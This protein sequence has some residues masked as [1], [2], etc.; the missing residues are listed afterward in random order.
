MLNQNT[1]F[2]FDINIRI[3]DEKALTLLA[4]PPQIVNIES[5]LVVILAAL[6]C[7]L[8]CEVGLVCSG[9][10]C[11]ASSSY[12]SQAAA[13]KGLKKKILKS[14]PKFTHASAAV[15]IAGRS[16]GM[17]RKGK[18]TRQVFTSRVTSFLFQYKFSLPFFFLF[19][20]PMKMLLSQ[21]VHEIGADTCKVCCFTSTACTCRQPFGF[22]QGVATT[23]YYMHEHD[24]NN[25]SGSMGNVYVAD[26]TQ[27]EGNG[28]FR[29]V[30]VHIRGPIDGLAGIGREL[31]LCQQLHGL[32]LVLSF[33][34]CLLGEHMER[35]YETELQGRL[36]GM[37]ISA[38]STSGIAVQMLESPEHAIGIE[39]EN[40]NSSSISLD[41]K[42]PL[43]HFPPFRFG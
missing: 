11:L 35:G 7:A 42:T 6:L 18:I 8:I 16:I 10:M 27:G 29:P 40:T 17:R 26:S 13:N 3:P 19:D 23:G 21:R 36:S 28:L 4:D 30:R 15:V 41:M 20:L 9:S 14:F 22:S 32:Q 33:P 5:D 2:C 31:H 43:N 12:P 37:S 39:W 38:P 25:S 34:V 1:S 24:H